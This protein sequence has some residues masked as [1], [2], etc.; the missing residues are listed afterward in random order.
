[1]QFV[2]VCVQAWVVWAPTT[3]AGWL[4]LGNIRNLFTRLRGKRDEGFVKHVIGMVY[5]QLNLEFTSLPE[6]HYMCCFW[7][8][9][10][11]LGKLSESEV[12]FK[13]SLEIRI[14]CKGDDDVLV[15]NTHFQ[16]SEVL[17]MQAK[18]ERQQDKKYAAISHARKSLDIR[19]KKLPVRNKASC[20][21]HHVYIIAWACWKTLVHFALA[22]FCVNLLS[23]VNEYLWIR[24]N[25]L[26]LTCAVD[27]FVS[28]TLFCDLWSQGTHSES[29]VLSSLQ[30]VSKFDY[31]LSEISV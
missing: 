30:D 29:A 6:N 25:M 13:E 31:D 8:V 15:A 16:M 17:I 11:N 26:L 19:T 14:L 20:R 1:M 12:L 2:I 5:H 10:Q 18:K 7:S 9:I 4:K 28:S 27:K 21:M 23:P 3:Q 22:I 24:N